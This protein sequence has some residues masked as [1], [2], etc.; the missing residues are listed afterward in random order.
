VL[1]GGADAGDGDADEI[2]RELGV[3]EDGDFS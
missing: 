1:E 3:D 2:R